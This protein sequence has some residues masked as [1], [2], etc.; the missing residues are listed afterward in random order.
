MSK[1]IKSVVIALMLSITFQ[2]TAL[3]GIKTVYSEDKQLIATYVEPEDGVYIIYGGDKEEQLLSA[4]VRYIGGGRITGKYSYPNYDNTRTG[5]YDLQ[6]VFTPDDSTYNPIYGTIKAKVI[7]TASG[8]M[9]ED[10][11][12]IPSLL[13]PTV[14]MEIGT[15]YTPQIINNIQGSDY[16]WK[17]SDMSVVKIN[18]KTGKMYAIKAGR[19]VVTC[20]ISTPYDDTFTLT[21][22][23]SVMSKAKVAKI[24]SDDTITLKAGEKITLNP[25]YDTSSSSARFSSTKSSVAKVDAYSGKITAKKQGTANIT[26]TIINTDYE[27]TTIYYTINVTE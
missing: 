23:V 21:A 14:S 22:E 3:A 20:K 6:W 7:I 18:K 16:L 1:L 11:D 26:C 19:A 8:T 12:A 13:S 17:T 2:Y 4:N 5:S 15:S 25:D 9:A 24:V 10:D 27:I